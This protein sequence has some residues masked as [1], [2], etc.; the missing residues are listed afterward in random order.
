MFNVG[1]V[2]SF[3]AGPI[4]FLSYNIVK[5]SMNSSNGGQQKDATHPTKIEPFIKRVSNAQALEKLFI[6]KIDL[7]KQSFG[8]QNVVPSEARS[9]L[10][11]PLLFT[12]NE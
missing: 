2:A 6:Y 7:S 5:I 10:V 9:S 8:S 4:N 12:D 1:W 11:L 3:C